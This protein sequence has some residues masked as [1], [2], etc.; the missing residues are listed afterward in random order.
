M[1][2]IKRW[3][4]QEILPNNQYSPLNLG[5]SWNEENR[6]NKYY[7][8]GNLTSFLANPTQDMTEEEH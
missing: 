6:E 3:S 1:V 2:H 7:F 5:F 8:P 4:T